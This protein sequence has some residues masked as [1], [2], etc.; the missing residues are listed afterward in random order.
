MFRFIREFGNI[1]MHL[2][3][4]LV[5]YIKAY[6]FFELGEERNLK[7]RISRAVKSLCIFLNVYF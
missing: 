1:L 7:I 4:Y 6:D 2:K 5:E 3:H